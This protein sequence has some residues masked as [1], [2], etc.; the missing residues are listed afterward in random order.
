[1]EITGAEAAFT[2]IVRNSE[3]RAGIV[4]GRPALPNSWA[5][6]RPYL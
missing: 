4:R 1:M 3:L 5:R 6:D 2:T